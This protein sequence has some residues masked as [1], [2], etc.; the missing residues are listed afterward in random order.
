MSVDD[1]TERQWINS[2]KMIMDFYKKGDYDTVQK[3]IPMMKKFLNEFED[4]I[5]ILKECK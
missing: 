2:V 1:I 3:M 4:T 5:K